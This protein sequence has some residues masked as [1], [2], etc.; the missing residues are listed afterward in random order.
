MSLIL[1]PQSAY[2]LG[3]V[4]K[5]VHTTC[6]L[7]AR[8]RVCV[9][10]IVDYIILCQLDAAARCEIEHGN[11]NNNNNLTCSIKVHFYLPV[12]FF[13]FFFSFHVRLH[14]IRFSVTARRRRYLVFGILIHDDKSRNYIRVRACIAIAADDDGVL[15]SFTLL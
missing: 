13:F 5:S 8:A 1:S 11:N 4:I 6:A 14:K 7:R 3:R 12:S 10:V 9:Y 15:R 2:T